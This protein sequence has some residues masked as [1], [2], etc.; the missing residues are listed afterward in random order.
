MRKLLLIGLDWIRRK[1]PPLSLAN[2]SIAAA[3]ASVAEVRTCTLNVNRAN[4]SN[5]HA[6]VQAGLIPLLLDASSNGSQPITVGLG[7]YIWA[8]HLLNETTQLIKDVL[9]RDTQVVLGGPQ[10]TYAP[11][12][13][14]A[15]HYP[16]ADGF[17]R[18]HGEEPMRRLLMGEAAPGFFLRDQ[19]DLGIQAKGGFISTPSPFVEG[20]MKPQ[21]FLRWETQRGCPF[22][23]SFCQHRDVKNERIALDQKRVFQECE[24]MV[25]QSI[26]GP[27]RDLA[28]VD[29]TFNSGA[30]YLEIMSRLEGL[31]AK[32]SLQCRLE[33]M[34]DD[35]VEA[36]L[37]LSRTA[38]VVLEF[39]VQTIHRVEQRQ[40]ER[41]SNMRRIDRWLECLNLH[42]VP[43][44][45]SFIYGLPEQTL[46][47]FKRTLEWAER[48]CSD[49]RDSRAAA[50]FFPLMLLRGTR[51]HDRAEELGLITDEHLAVDIS[52][53]VG[54]HIPHV[55]ASPT[56]SFED[57]LVMNREAERVNRADLG[58]AAH[59]R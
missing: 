5:V 17:I 35:F 13:T 2:A 12:G 25:N 4:S 53:R 15:S 28:V 41:P 14:L 36:V 9:G 51:L 11:I 32:L 22:A 37:E 52:G 21:R 18:G 30:N 33:M 49:H 3:C 10:V 38:D 8:D 1:D 58:V 24:W 50:R 42:G 45:I 46:D 23:C 39:G 57:W 19:D 31:R 56:F 7:G 59:V 48:K 44:E 20:W 16:L 40:I 29:P 26:D 34:S 54:S 27:L 55:I 6:A 43:Y 47:S